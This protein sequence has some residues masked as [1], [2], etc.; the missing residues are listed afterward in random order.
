MWGF[1]HIMHNQQITSILTLPP[2]HGLI[3]H[4]G[5]AGLRPENTLTGFRHA[6]ELG[7]NWVEFDVQLTSCGVWVVFHDASVELSQNKFSSTPS[8]KSTKITSL[9][10]STLRQLNVGAE[11]N[12]TYYPA[13]I[14]TLA[15]VLA[16]TTSLGLQS[17][18]EVKVYPGV[19]PQYYA[20]MLTE[21]LQTVPALLTKPTALVAATKQTSLQPLVSSFD[22]TVLQQLRALLPQQPLGYL[23]DN[24]TADTCA[25]ATDN[26]FDTINCAVQHI[27][28][29]NILAA[30]ALNLPVLL[31]T[32][33]DPAIA[34]YWLASGAA[35]VFT[36]RPDLLQQI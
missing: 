28:Q 30:N 33:N 21:F 9:P 4:R 35:A 36:D 10:L 34:K 12:G 8:N 18:I 20:Q 2:N 14:P 17:N 26:A 6:A 11:F 31:Y 7:L 23:I 27:T 29:Q 13:T 15:E 25:I 19:D 5:V 16:L 24:F 32:V 1:Q 22:L 3:G